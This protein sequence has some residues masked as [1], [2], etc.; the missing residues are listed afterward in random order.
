M[1][2]NNPKDGYHAVQTAEESSE[3]KRVGAKAA[4][5]D[6]G[7]WQDT[8]NLPLEERCCCS[9]LQR[10]ASPYV[11]GVFVCVLNFFQSAAFSVTGSSQLSTIEKRFQLKTSEL[12]PFLIVNDIMSVVMV[13]FVAYYGHTSHRPRLIGGGSLL[14]GLGFLL[15]TLPQ[16]I[17]D[18]PPQFSPGLIG[19]GRENGSAGGFSHNGSSLLYPVCEVST[20]GGD[21]GSEVCTEEEELSSGSLMW[22]VSWIIVGQILG[23]IGAAPIMPLAVTYMDDCLHRSSTS[24]Y[25]AFMFVASSFGPLLGAGISGFCLSTHADFYKA[26]VQAQLGDP[27]WLGAWWLS[28]AMVGVLLLIVGVPIMMFPKK[29]RRRVKKAKDGERRKSEEAQEGEGGEDENMAG[30]Y[31]LNVHE[32]GGGRCAYVKGFLN[33]LRRLVTNLTFMSLL[34]GVCAM[35]SSVVGIIVFMVKYLETQFGLPASTAPMLFGIIMPPGSLLGNLIGG[36]VVKKLKLT[37]KGLARMVV[38]MKPFVF[39]LAPVF[40]LLGCS[41]RDIAGI[42][43][44]YPNMN[45]TKVPLPNLVAGCNA[46]CACPTEY[47]PVCGSDGVTYA[48]P[49]HAGCL[50]KVENGQPNGTKDG[51]MLYTDC[52]CI[53]ATSPADPLG[54]RGDYEHVAIPGECPRECNTLIP[55]MGVA[56]LQVLLMT[57]VGN[58]GFM[59]QLRTVDEDDR[60]IA[61]GFSSML[62]RLLGFIPSPLIFGTV[63]QTTCLLLQSSCG[64]TGNCLLYDIVQFRYVYFGLIFSLDFLSLVLFIV[65]YCSIRVEKTPQGFEEMRSVHSDEVKK[66]ETSPDTTPGQDKALEA[67][68]ESD[69]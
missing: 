56:M 21:A 68:K 57:I 65:C 37:K 67:Y 51:M 19:G 59:L 50:A 23:G 55:F 40:L 61:V 9:A 5:E 46:D 29:I 47:T 1:S 32:D 24:V 8:D 38:V 12:A 45:M 54:L 13:L 42:T 58:P 4:D 7:A 63:I 48:T 2:N 34:L 60:S 25:V 11:F 18:T 41:N 30:M 27:N 22:Q 64:K 39:L 49:C 26:P 16:F 52:G 6:E 3:R 66:S 10:L 15:S 69:V 43:T 33:A 62:L 28:F 53:G 17:Y 35:L 31:R 20:S 44:A 36:F 14:I